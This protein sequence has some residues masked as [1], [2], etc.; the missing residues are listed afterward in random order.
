MLCAG[1]IQWM[2]TRWGQSCSY[3]VSPVMLYSVV[4][5]NTVT[6]HH[7][8][9]TQEHANYIL[10]SAT[11]TQV[12]TMAFYGMYKTGPIAASICS[13]AQHNTKLNS[14]H[15]RKSAAVWLRYKHING[16]QTRPYQ[17]CLLVYDA[18]PEILARTDRPKKEWRHHVATASAWC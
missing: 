7:V 17:L 1:H 14:N 5:R 16:I 10:I 18:Q 3:N 13:W 15:V 8:L 12:H 4:S 9:N 2:Y 11:S 6:V